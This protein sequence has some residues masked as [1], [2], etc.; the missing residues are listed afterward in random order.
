MKM[1]NIRN[2]KIEKTK[3]I[4]ESK[5][6]SFF[7]IKKYVNKNNKKISPKK[8]I[9]KKKK[10][11]SYIPLHHKAGELY[12]YHL[13]KIELN[14]KNNEIQKELQEKKEMKKFNKQKLNEK[15]WNNFLDR[16]N[17]WKQ[18]NINIKK[19]SLKKK[20]KKDKN[21]TYDRPKINRKSIIMLE[22]KETSNKLKKNNIVNK[23]YLNSITPNRYNNIY[24]KLYKD[25]DIYDTKLK[26]RIYNSMPTFSPIIIDSK[27]QRSL[28]KNNNKSKINKTPN[29]IKYDYKRKAE[30]KGIALKDD[31]NNHIKNLVSSI[32]TKQ[33]NQRKKNQIKDTKIN[34]KK[35]F[36][37]ELNI[38]NSNYNNKNDNHSIKTP[39]ISS[40]IKKLG[41]SATK[42]FIIN[43]KNIYQKNLSKNN[44]LPNKKQEN[45]I[46]TFQSKNNNSKLSDKE[47]KEI[48]DKDKKR[49]EIEINND[50]KFLYN[51]NLSDHTSNNMKQFV[52]LDFYL[53]LN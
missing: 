30:K 6:K 42:K 33:I 38:N 19:E 40:Y 43:K 2:K 47:N 9:L 29:K 50:T 23:G 36:L 1:I 39:N 20:E 53:F 26:N 37:F 18:N 21:K 34:S 5:T 41:E 44:L 4:R 15:T 45:K 32:S 52:V 24:T 48:N 35:T 49:K 25:K 13:A 10:E 8:S 14:Q 27:R 46:N 31:N 28:T 17:Q 7:D 16:E 3:E 11:K 12:K 22:N 51:I